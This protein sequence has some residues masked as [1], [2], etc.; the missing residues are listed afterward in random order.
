MLS[1]TVVGMVLTKTAQSLC[2]W[3]VTSKEFHQRRYRARFPLAIG[4]CA[5]AYRLQVLCRRSRLSVRDLPCPITRYSRLE[6]GIPSALR[7]LF[8]WHS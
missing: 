4:V 2:Y 7:G 5:A 8:C 6:S 1:G 3:R